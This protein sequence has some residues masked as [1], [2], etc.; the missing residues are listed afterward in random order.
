MIEEEIRRLS[1]REPDHSLD[2]LEA[3]IWN[4]LIAQ[5]RRKSRS[6]RFAALQAIVLGVVFSIGAF[7]GRYYGAHANRTTELSVFSTDTQF[8]RAILVGGGAP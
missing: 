3:D 5:E 7:T 4:R 1:R 6:A 2:A 8:S